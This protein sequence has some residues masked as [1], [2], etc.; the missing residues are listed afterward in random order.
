MPAIL[1][2]YSHT[3]M[4]CVAQAS[5]EFSVPKIV[6]LGIIKTESGGNVRAVHH[7]RNGTYDYGVMQI[8][9]TWIHKLWHDYGIKTNYAT[10]MKPCYN[11]RVGAWI[12]HRELLASG[13]MF[14]SGVGNY[15]SHSKSRNR[16]YQQ[17]IAKNIEWISMNTNWQQ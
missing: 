9:S 11:I 10:L 5:E 16:D 2:P 17:K 8:N 12:L 14:W 15:H 6:I 1:P 4:Q 13:S 3:V 7:N